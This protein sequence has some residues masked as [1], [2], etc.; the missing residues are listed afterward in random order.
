MGGDIMNKKTCAQ[1]IR[2]ARLRAG[3]TQKE[4]AAKLG[5]KSYQSITQWE[6]GKR[7][8]KFETLV[9]IDNALGSNIVGEL[10]VFDPIWEK[11][12]KKEQALLSAFDV[13]N[14]EGQDRAV[15]RVEELGEIPKYQKPVR[16]FGEILDEFNKQRAEK[17][18]AEGA[19]P[20]E[21]S[22]QH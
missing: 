18:E 2:E 20:G 7:N 4:L 12:S 8:P 1:L 21:Q 17:H 22:D 13:L 14:D 3:L 15:E 9:D 10:I 11:L 5:L 16:P 6:N 19:S